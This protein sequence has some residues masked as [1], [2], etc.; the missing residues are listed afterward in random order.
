MRPVLGGTW[1]RKAAIGLRRNIGMEGDGI[2]H[3]PTQLSRPCDRGKMGVFRV[4]SL[5][6]WLA[7]G[8]QEGIG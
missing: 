5:G 6:A 2:G 7:V 8:S 3:A 1:R 4:D